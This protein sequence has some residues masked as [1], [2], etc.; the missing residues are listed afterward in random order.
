[1]GH[2]DVIPSAG[3]YD[4]EMKIGDVSVTVRAAVF[5]SLATAMVLGMDYLLVNA[6]AIDIP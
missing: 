3:T 6:I 5:P 2:G 4:L 1:M